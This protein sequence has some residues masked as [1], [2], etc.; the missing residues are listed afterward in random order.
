MSWKRHRRQFLLFLTAILLPAALLIGLAARVI[1]QEAEL[2][3]TRAAAE[4][5]AG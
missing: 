3:E 1:R 5:R 4:V 2:E